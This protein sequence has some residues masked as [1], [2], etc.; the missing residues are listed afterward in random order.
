MQLT[1]SL[2]QHFTCLSLMLCVCV[3]T[4]MYVSRAGWLAGWLYV[5]EARDTERERGKRA[6]GRAAA[7]LLHRRQ[8]CSWSKAK[9]ESLCSALSLPFTH[10]F[11]YSTALCTCMKPASH[12]LN[13]RSGDRVSL[14]M[15]TFAAVSVWTESGTLA[16]PVL[17]VIV[18]LYQ[19]KKKEFRVDRK[20]DFLSVS[21]ESQ[22]DAE[23]QQK[24]CKGCRS[25][26]FNTL[27]STAEN[28]KKAKKSVFHP[29]L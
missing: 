3:W 23:K 28:M 13:E 1:S 9:Q 14:W 6:W 21:F 19:R 15:C 8:F 11:T 7:A 10:S 26:N 25:T 24:S 12:V 20:R 5:A 29:L 17:R 22:R 18:S 16:K 2:P 27:S 4:N